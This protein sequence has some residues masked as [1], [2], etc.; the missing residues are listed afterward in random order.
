MWKVHVNG[1]RLPAEVN[2]NMLGL[3]SL[4]ISIITNNT[5]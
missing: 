5:F 4:T 2:D 1:K 3:H